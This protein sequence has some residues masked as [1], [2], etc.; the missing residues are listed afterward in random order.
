MEMNSSFPWTIHRMGLG[1]WELGTGAV[2]DL[3]KGSEAWM[4]ISRTLHPT[5]LFR[6]LHW[7]H[8]FG[9]DGHFWLNELLV[10]SQGKRRENTCVSM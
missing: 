7:P 3:T 8:P 6:T 1:S 2:T 9:V 10:R 5:N 4:D